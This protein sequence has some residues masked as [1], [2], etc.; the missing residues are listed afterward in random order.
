MA[1][2]RFFMSRVLGWALAGSVGLSAACGV[3]P[4]DD[5]KKKIN[6]A[7][8]LST[9]FPAIRSLNDVLVLAPD[10]AYAVGTGGA[11]LRYD[12]E[13]WSEEDSGVTVDLQAIAG[14]VEGQE[15][16][17]VEH[18]LVVGAEGT[19]LQ[20]GAEPGSWVV[21]PSGTTKLLFSV[22]M[23]NASDAFIVGD[24]GLILRYDGTALIDMTPQTLQLVVGND[25]S[26]N[27]F[28]IPEALKGVGDAG[29]AMLAVGA[30]GAVY[31]F[32]PSGGPTDTT[33]KWAREESGTTRSLAGVFT[34]N[35]VWVPTTDGVLMRRNGP[36]DWDDDSTR[37]PAPVFLQDV[38]VDGEVWAV[39][40]SE[41]IYNLNGKGW[42]L[43]T[44]SDSAEMRA[45]DGTFVPPPE[46]D[47]EA[48]PSRLIFAVGGGG[49]IARG[50]L[51]L[52]VE[53]ETQLVTRPAA[54]D[55]VQ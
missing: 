46:D 31:A 12:G 38:Y 44:V 35:G 39:G 28:P 45:V 11:V 30:R 33:T 22:A 54:D 23:R 9:P 8:A 47:P 34:E 21:V 36:G 41:D 7:W 2:T 25:G 53:G 10:R 18:L 55:F 50:P 20:R 43:T 16:D 6:P 37:T 29:D 17:L 13:A 14:F 1:G 15:P 52:P 40:L 42:Q 26:Q 19:V 27:F 4:P 24:A 3:A 49:R 5:E 48:G 32:D 51:V